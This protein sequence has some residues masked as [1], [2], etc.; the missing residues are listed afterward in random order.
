[1]QLVDQSQV[2][3]LQPLQRRWPKA[4]GVLVLVVGF[5]ILCHGLKGHGYKSRIL[6]RLFPGL[7]VWLNHPYITATRPN[8]YEDGVSPDAF[9]AADVQLPNRGHVVDAATVS[10]GSVRLIRTGDQQPIEAQVN[11]SGAGDSVV[12]KPTQSLDLNTEYTF[13][14]LPALK[15][16]GGASFRH[17]KVNFTTAATHQASAFPAAFDVVPLPQTHGDRY[18]CVT[19]GPDHRL[20]AAT[21]EGRIVRFDIAADGVVANAQPFLAVQSCNGGPRT[22]TGILF[23]PAATA[24]NLI[25]WVSHGQPVNTHTA[26]WTSKISRL[27][28]PNL[29][30]YQDFIVGLPRG[31]RD[32][33]V[34]QMVFGPEGAL[35]F[36]QASNTA[37]GAPDSQWNYRPERLMSAA[38]LRANLNAITAPP[39]NVTTADGGGRYDPFAA[40]APL[41]LYAT[42]VRNAFDLLWHSNGRLYAPI[43]GSSAGGTAP[44]TPDLSNGA[45]L[46]RRIDADL[47]GT[48]AEPP[49][50]GLTNV[51]ITEQDTFIRVE[52]GGYYGHPDPARAEFV[53][54]GGHPTA[55]SSPYEVPQYP[56]GTAPDRNW[57]L[58]VFDFGKNLAPCGLIEYKSPACPAL[59]GKILVTRFS[60]GKDILV[61]APGRGGEISESISGIDGFTRLASPLSLVEDTSTGYLYVSEFAA[62]QITLLRPKAGDSR[63]VFRQRGPKVETSETPVTSQR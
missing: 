58:P 37:M 25:L 43:N 40:D 63:R 4:M 61:L 33:L 46:P 20:Y 56:V 18:T 54:N 51:P 59:D 1:M 48:Y 14:V 16:T 38:I 21:L 57:R 60:G 19:L 9:I 27:S 24:S 53:L 32:H 22:I 47:K 36:G 41:T 12:L 62:K 44:G 34:N 13:E 35:Y 50:P 30:N 10:S 5:V 39:L 29:E 52:K 3:T 42:G 23:D 28:G 45:S 7:G 2:Q 15:D 8:N 11:T 55:A 49:V 26:D 17:F 31:S 6:H